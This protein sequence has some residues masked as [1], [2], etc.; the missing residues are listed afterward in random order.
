M[1]GQLIYRQAIECAVNDDVREEWTKYLEETEDHERILRETFERIGLG[2][3]VET[4]GR[5]I[6]RS[7]AEAL[8]QG[9]SA[10]LRDANGTGRCRQG[11]RTTRG[12]RVD[13]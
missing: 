10:G 12:R 1:G 7:K 5:M 9:G 8:E 13:R 4:P 11:R 2:A 3:E 6:V